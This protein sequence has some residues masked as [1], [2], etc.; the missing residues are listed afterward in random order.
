MS[1]SLEYEIV[2]DDRLRDTHIFANTLYYITIFSS[3][4]ET[5][6]IAKQLICIIQFS[7]LVVHHHVLVVM[8]YIK[9]SLKKKNIRCRR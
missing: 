1:S 7:E 3:Q 2:Y 6:V 5:K 9:Q 8:K 4:E